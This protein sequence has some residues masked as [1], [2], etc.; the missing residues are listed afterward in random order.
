MNYYNENDPKTAAWLK[1]LIKA[2]LI[3]AGEVDER[4]ICDVAP[5]D[6]NGFIQCHFFA[7]IGGWSCALRLA[8]WPEDQPVWTGSCPCQ[9]FSSATRGLSKGLKDE[10]HLWPE[11]IRLIND[12]RPAIVFGE[13]VSNA[14][15]WL[16]VVCD[17]MEANNYTIRA[18]IIPAYSAGA[19]HARERI[20]FACYANNKSE[21][22]LP[23]NAETPRM[24]WPDCK[25]FGM[26]PKNGIPKGMA[27][28]GFGNAI[29][30]Q[31]ASVFIQS[32]MEATNALHRR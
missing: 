12:A 6:L 20:Y 2:K 32:A 15:P 16:D 7:G 9:P 21:S 14:L 31:V 8:G 24:L 4:S 25:S 18:A 27:Y 29:V 5:K 26:V 23:V 3:P 13:Q 28:R 11:F 10:K 30:P 17:D 22:R 19:D 1:E